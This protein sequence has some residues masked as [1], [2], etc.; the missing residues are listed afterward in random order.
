MRKGPMHLVGVLGVRQPSN[1]IAIFMA[2]MN[3]PE[4]RVVTAIFHGTHSSE[5][6]KQRPLAC[7]GNLKESVWKAH[8]IIVPVRMIFTWK[9]FVQ[10]RGS[11]SKSPLLSLEDGGIRER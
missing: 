6:K 3:I 7:N 10:A 4:V 2:V 5:V 1:N 9:S 8:I 11:N